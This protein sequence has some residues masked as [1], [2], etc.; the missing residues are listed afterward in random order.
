M[1]QQSMAQHVPRPGCDLKLASP[2]LTSPR[3]DHVLRT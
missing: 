1:G 2:R 3:L